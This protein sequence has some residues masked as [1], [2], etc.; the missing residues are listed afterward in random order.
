MATHTSTLAWRIP[1]TEEQDRLQSMESQRVGQDCATNFH[2]HKASTSSFNTIPIK[3][4]M[5]FFTEIEQKISKSVWRHE[6]T[7]IVRAIFFFFFFFLIYLWLCWFFVAVWAFSSWG[8]WV[9]LSSRCARAS[10][11]SGSSCCTAQALGCSGFSSCG[12]KALGHRL[13]SRG[14]QA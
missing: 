9:L 10:H 5:T 13:N 8:K 2:F 12:S 1:W 4:P 14:T 6:R 3:L 7:R 11:C